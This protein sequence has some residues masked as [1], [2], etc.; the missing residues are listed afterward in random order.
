MMVD[1]AD[2]QEHRERCISDR[3]FRYRR[4]ARPANVRVVEAGGG[5][6]LRVRHDILKTTEAQATYT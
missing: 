5:Y 4:S 1:S 6:D 2:Q 3:W